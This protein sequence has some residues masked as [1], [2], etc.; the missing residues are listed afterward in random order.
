[1]PPVTCK[2][3][4]QG[5]CRFGGN[6]QVCSK[7]ENGSKLTAFAEKCKFEHPS[8]GGGV[9][10]G[11][12]FASLQSPDH[13]NTRS[14][15]YQQGGASGPGSSV[16][17]SLDKSQIVTD[18]SS[19]KPQ[20]I[21]SAYGPGRQAPAQLFGGPMREQ[22]FEEMRLLH[23]MAIASGNPQQAVQEAEKLFQASEQQIH[24][25]LNDV[26]GAINF[27]INAQNEHPNRIDFVQGT[28]V[29]TSG[30]QPNPFGQPNGAQPTTSNIFGA[31]RQPTAPA[32]GAPSQGTA[33]AFGAP[34]GG[35]AFGQPPALGAK[36]NP[37]A[38]PSAFGAPS[39][40]GTGGAFGQ[41]SQVGGGGA[42]G[43]P[44]QL[45]GGGAFGQPSQPGG[46]G[47]FGQPSSLGQK[48]NPFGAPSG[49]SAFGGTSN[50]TAA[51]FSA[52]AN[53]P[54]PLSQGAAPAT[55]GTFG[56]PSQPTT[57]APFGTTP[58]PASSNPFGPP[59]LQAPNPFGGVSSAPFGAPSP[60][61]KNPFA[62]VP[63]VQSQ[64]N[65]G[66]TPAPNPFSSA[67]PN[68]PTTNPLGNPSANTTN[69]MP[70][71]APP[72]GING[73]TG[74]GHPPISSYSSK[75]Q[76]GRLTMFKGRRVV[77]QK[78]EPGVRNQDGSWSKIW[79]PEGPPLPYKDTEMDE[80]AY[81]DGTKAAYTQ[82][83]QTGSF[84]GGVMPLLPPMREWCSWDF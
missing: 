83:R 30:S 23:Y 7:R 17:F 49:G 80:S 4:M 25:A 60:A 9:P 68:T 75:D 32:F 5:N 42:F 33:P 39:Q 22:S 59:S 34:S 82:M 27:I 3:W 53:A 57:S 79:F 62:T 73:N 74:T 70:F 11:N 14:N 6:D 29:P 13:T 50:A 10:N 19:E 12:R 26:D 64:N 46:G 45:G 36:P 15:G 24:T 72:P 69:S 47:A 21:L 61:A 58:Q 63:P 55:T 37:F 44:S 43:Q 28:Q 41:P 56:A 84:L 2:F 16:P 35:P 8:R 67:Q 51:P 38:T 18:L 77:Y 40:P 78:D 54:N 48:P 65:F 31:P 81:D 76:S 20:W 71:G 1:M 52:F 66:T